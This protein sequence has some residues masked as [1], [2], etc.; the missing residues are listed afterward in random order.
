V[1]DADGASGGVTSFTVTFTE[2]LDPSTAGVASKYSVDPDGPGPAAAVVPASAVLSSSTQNSA[3]LASN[4]AQAWTTVAITL[5][6]GVTLA[7]GATITQSVKD[8]VGNHAQ[9]TYALL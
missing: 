3:G 6:S 9:Q 5:P 2:A 1:I 7:S 8:L 4:L